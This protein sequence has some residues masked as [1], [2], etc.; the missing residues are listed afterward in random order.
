MMLKL[1]RPLSQ[2]T[3]MSVQSQLTMISMRHIS[4][5]EKMRSIQQ[6]LAN[7]DKL[8]T[9]SDSA[10]IKKILISVEDSSVSFKNAKDKNIQ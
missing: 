5:H 6:D 1:A 2:V 7:P 4:I 3:K 8:A 10:N 9:L